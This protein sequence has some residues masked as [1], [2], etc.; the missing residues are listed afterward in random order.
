MI[1][2]PPVSELIP[3]TGPMVLLEEMTTWAVGSAEC[4]VRIRPRSAFV[5]D[6]RV[7]AS[8]TLEYMAQAVAACLGY[9]ARLGGN[10]MRVGMLIACKVFTAHDSH[11]S[12]GD[13]V[14]VTVAR[15]SGNESISQF[16]CRLRREGQPFAEAV[17]T[18]YHSEEPPP[19]E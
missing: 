19:D 2:L 10:E 18:V 8:V 5:V 12:V 11:L 16:E 17:L 7:E 1:A 14:T 13:E 9:Q 3:H 15:V 6:G 4:R